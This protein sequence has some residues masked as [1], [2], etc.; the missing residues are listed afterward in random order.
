MIVEIL[1]PDRTG[2][3][4]SL[5]SAGAHTTSNPNPQQTR[6]WR[7]GWC[8]FARLMHRHFHPH[9]ACPIL[10]RSQSH[11]TTLGTIQS[12][13]VVEGLPVECAFA[14]CFGPGSQSLHLC[15]SN[16]DLNQLNPAFSRPQSTPLRNDAI[17]AM[18]VR[19]SL[20]V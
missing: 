12:S 10:S 5:G 11:P 7:P 2:P 20:P 3:E 17:A 18:L 19:S 13:V 16:L 6:K 14:V 8:S 1:S 4:G 9:Q 15:E